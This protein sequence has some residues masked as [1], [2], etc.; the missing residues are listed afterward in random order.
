M[1][2][3]KKEESK[4]NKMGTWNQL[5]FFPLLFILQSNRLKIFYFSDILAYILPSSKQAFLFRT[6]ILPPK[7]I[8]YN[9]PLHPPTASYN[10]S[11]V[12]RPEGG[13]V[14]Q[15]A[16]VAALAAQEAACCQPHLSLRARV[17]QQ[18]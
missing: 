9:P 13:L 8:N 4:Q 5:F 18:R 2:N 11:S 15:R 6:P 10:T 16:A 17:Y 12:S 3:F 14:A 7:Q 1:R